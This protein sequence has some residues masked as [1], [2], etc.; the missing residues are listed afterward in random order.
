MSILFIAYACEPDSISESFLAYE[1]ICG[2]AERLNDEVHVLTRSNNLKACLNDKRAKELGIVWHGCD[3]GR[4]L[5]WMK[6]HVP[7]FSIQFYAIYWQFL[8]AKKARE[9][10]QVHSFDL[11][12]GLSMMS[13]HNFAAG[14]TGLASITGPIG[15]AQEIPA[16]LHR[17]G[18]PL[19]EI[20]RKL[21]LHITPHIPHW[22][23]SIH[24]VRRMICANEETKNYLQHQEIPAEKIAV[25]QPGYP[26]VCA[27]GDPVSE[28]DSCQP[29]PLPDLVS[30]FWGGRLVR[31]KG[32]EVLLDAMA[33]A[34][35]VGINM[36]LHVTGD[37]PDRKRFV[38]MASHLGI[39]D[40]VEFHGWLPKE[41]MCRLR[42]TCHLLMF[43]SL[44]ETTG[45]ALIEMLLSNRPVAV[46]DCGGP[47]EIIRGLPCFIICPDRAGMELVDAIRSVRD[48]FP[49]AIRNAR[50]TA[51]QSLARF[52]W[53][54]YL[55]DLCGW[56]AEVT[57]E[58]RSL[59]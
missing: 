7:F 48:D 56:Y 45:L 1:T 40:S 51:R 19:Q 4:T 21:S 55:T 47:S 35:G 17:Y 37:G 31:C 38:K 43:T 41:E 15:G 44:R 18:D 20:F 13:L 11:V 5:V 34:R 9:L 33:T 16:A 30:V 27:S 14:L 52:D 54:A 39:A 49:S 50:E 8:A 2:I 58:K 59:L 36:H 57:A 32:L 24:S 3:G 10:A 6:K 46:L 25:R 26:G 53:D 42:S 23:N 28:S 22:K 29:E 12:H